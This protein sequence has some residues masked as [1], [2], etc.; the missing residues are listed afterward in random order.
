MSDIRRAWLILA[1]SERSCCSRIFFSVNRAYRLSLI[2]ARRGRKSRSN[3]EG[4]LRSIKS[5]PIYSFT[6]DCL[7]MRHCVRYL[8]SHFF[9][10]KLGYTWNSSRTCRCL[11]L[12]SRFNGDGDVHLAI[13]RQ[14]TSRRPMSKEVSCISNN[15][16]W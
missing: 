9:T 7:Q 13:S 16:S 15:Q 2:H 1:L 14:N 4:V 10:S 11:H 5:K 8:F 6:L 12:N 3:F